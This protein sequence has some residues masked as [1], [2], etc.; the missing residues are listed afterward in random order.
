MP[1]ISYNQPLKN[2]FFLIKLTGKYRASIGQFYMIR[3]D[4]QA[5]FLGRPMSVYDIEEDGIIFLYKVVGKGT[6]VLA[7]CKKDENIAINGP[8]GHGF[9]LE[10]KGRIA[11]VGGGTGIA[12]LFFALKQLK[13]YSN[14]NLIHVYLGLQQKNIFE[15]EFEYYADHLTV[16][17]GGFITD[18]IQYEQYNTIFSCGPEIMMKKIESQ[19]KIY[20]FEHYV[21]I[22]SRMA[23]GVGACLVCSCKTKNGNVRV[24][25]DGPVFRGEDIFYNE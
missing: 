8:Y 18:H 7:N 6:S 13:K 9:P 12:P 19:A 21:S 4:S 24:C 25:K 5:I 23:C 20:H 1:L 14:I 17:Y 15:S 16:N 10:V 11:L 2:N 22:E 3:K